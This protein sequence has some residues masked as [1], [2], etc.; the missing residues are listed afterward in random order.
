VEHNHTESLPS[1]PP[2]PSRLE[3]TNDL[4]TDSLAKDINTS[5][6][7]TS[8][9]KPHAG[10]AQSE[11]SV[12]LPDYGSD[13]NAEGEREDDSTPWK[14]DQVIVQEDSEDEDDMEEVPIPL[15]QTL[16]PKPAVS[17]A[18]V[19]DLFRNELALDFVNTSA[20]SEYMD[21]SS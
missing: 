8:E 17:E 18:E 14:Q 9:P 6:T 11:D 19:S 5:E 12:G 21:F 20:A 16:E 2:V 15:S 7:P 10:E 1:T 3:S 4:A 13:E